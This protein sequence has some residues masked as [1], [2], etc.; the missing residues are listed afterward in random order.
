MAQTSKNPLTQHARR[1]SSAFVEIAE[2]LLE[3]KKWWMLPI[4][5]VLVVFG[6][7]ML[8]GGT[9]AAPFVYTLF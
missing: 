2:Y 4:L 8:L 7:L 9:A 5:V 6:A 3:N 1:R